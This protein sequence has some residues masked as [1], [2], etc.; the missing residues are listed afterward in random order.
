[1]FDPKL[2]ITR[3]KKV[4]EVRP[5]IRWGKGSAV[6]QIL[7][8]TEQSRRMLPVFIGDDTTDEDVFRILRHRGITIR[9]GKDKTTHAMHYIK[10][11]GEVMQLL[12]SLI[13]FRTGR[14]SFQKGHKKG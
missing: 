9:V 5:R 8:T 11:V 10:N 2:V 1:M 12:R 6:L 3:G 4:L 7:K 14:S 13:A